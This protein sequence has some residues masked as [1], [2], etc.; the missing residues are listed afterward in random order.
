MLFFHTESRLD[1]KVPKAA[2][3]WWWL[4]IPESLAYGKHYILMADL[5]TLRTHGLWN[6]IRFTFPSLTMCWRTAGNLLKICTEGEVSRL[7]SGKSFQDRI[8]ETAIARCTVVH[9]NNKLSYGF[10]Y[11]YYS[12]LIA[13]MMKRYTN[14]NII[15]TVHL[16]KTTTTIYRVTL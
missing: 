14:S 1:P 11:N 8:E 3:E 13:S 9:L 6:E 16:Q 4:I 7:E 10:L 5:S 2:G 15:G 12:F